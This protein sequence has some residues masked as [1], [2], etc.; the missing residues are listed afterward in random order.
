MLRINDSM[1]QVEGVTITD[2]MAAALE[3]SRKAAREAAERQRKEA[4]RKAAE[5]ARKAEGGLERAR[6]A[7][8]KARAQAKG[9]KGADTM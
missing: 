7:A 3:G 2:D 1:I 6:R 5:A 4:A 9:L 8:V